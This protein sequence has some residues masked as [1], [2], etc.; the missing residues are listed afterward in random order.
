[1]TYNLPGLDELELAILLLT[2]SLEHTEVTNG[3]L[4][5]LQLSSLGQ[6]ERQLIHL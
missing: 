6:Q 4:Q 2:Q 1:M 5:S 3:R